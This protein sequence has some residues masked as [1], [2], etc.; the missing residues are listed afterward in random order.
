MDWEGDRYQLVDWG[1]DMVPSGGLGRRYGACWWTG[2]EIGSAG[3][4]GRKYGACW[5]TGEEIGISWWTGEAN[6]VSFQQ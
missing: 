2:E 5:W 3:G 1:G 6:I 4:L